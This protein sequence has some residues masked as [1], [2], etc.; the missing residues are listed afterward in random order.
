MLTPQETRAV[1]YY[2]GDITWVPADDPFLCDPKAYCSLNA[3]LFEGL[4]TE[5]T[6]IAEGKKLN[7]ELLRQPARLLELYSLLFSAAEKGALQEDTICRRVERAGDFE[8]CAQAGETL[9]FTSTCLDDFLPEYGDKHGMVLLSYHVPAGTPCIVFMSLLDDYL[10]AN[11]NEL[12]L[13]PYLSF[14]YR[15]RPLTP[16][17]QR[18]ADMDGKPPLAAYDITVTGKTPPGTALPFGTEPFEPGIRIW[19]HLNSGL[20]AE[21]LSPDDVQA[22]TAWKKALH[23]RLRSLQSG[24]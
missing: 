6:R 11:E 21:Q 23:S 1:K 2:E 13:P 15:E 20:S 14:A 22:Y 7:T 18:M 24:R 3:L 17:E 5:Q 4:Q 12:L 8:K 19:E 16:A 10:K 9:A